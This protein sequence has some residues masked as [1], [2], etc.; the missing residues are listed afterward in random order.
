M[1]KTDFNSVNTL[2]TSYRLSKRN[3]KRICNVKLTLERAEAV[4]A[5]DVRK[6]AAAMLVNSPEEVNSA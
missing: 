5:V 6:W 3:V 4:A 1:L 2:L